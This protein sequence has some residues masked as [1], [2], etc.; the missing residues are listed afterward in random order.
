VESSADGPDYDAC[1]LMWDMRGRIDTATPP[2]G[3]T[4]MPFDDADTPAAMR[5][6]WLVVE[7]GAVDLRQSDP[8]FEVDL[9][10]KTTVRAMGRVWFGR[11]DLRAAIAAEEVVLHG[12]V[13]LARSIGRWSM[14]T[15]DV[16]AAAIQ[17]PAGG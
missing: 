10:A 14:S 6:W 11:R 5:R 9:V 4:L 12:D 7:A 17:R 15:L 16:E 2:A 1:V 8:G 13:E 3:R